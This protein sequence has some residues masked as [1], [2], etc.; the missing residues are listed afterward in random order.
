MTGNI[1]GIKN[2]NPPKFPNIKDKAMKKNIKPTNGFFCLFINNLL[3]SA[4]D[5]HFIM[6]LF[7]HRNVIKSGLPRKN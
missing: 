2:A 3:P 7:Y 4:W 6:H 5:Y 1:K